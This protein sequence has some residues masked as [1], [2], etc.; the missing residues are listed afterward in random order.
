[1]ESKIVIL[2]H[3]MS[4]LSD[5][6]QQSVIDYSSFLV[7]QSEQPLVCREEVVANLIERPAQETL[8]AAIERL[9]ASYFMLDSDDMLNDVSVL[10]GRHILQ[11]LEVS[12]AID[13]LQLCFQSYYRQYLNND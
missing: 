7:H 4:R 8:A 2:E 11:G 12:V 10:M 1:M 3:L 5:D 9:K 6:Q 13:E